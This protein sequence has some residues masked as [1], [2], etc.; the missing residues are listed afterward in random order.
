M[1]PEVYS[2]SD[3]AGITTKNFK[4]YYGY[5]VEDEN[6]EWCFQASFNDETITIPFSKSIT[7]N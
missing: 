4:A 2:S 7:K 5:E 6:E 3:Y 1:K